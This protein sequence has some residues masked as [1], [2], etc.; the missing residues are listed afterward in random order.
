MNNKKMFIVR[1]DSGTIIQVLS[2]PVELPDY[3]HTIKTVNGSKIYTF[4][5]SYA[6]G[7]FPVKELK[8]KIKKALERRQ[9]IKDEAI[10]DISDSKID[11]HQLH[12]ALDYLE[13]AFFYREDGKNSPAYKKLQDQ[14]I[15]A[16]SLL[17]VI[18]IQNYI[19]NCF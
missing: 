15:N 1:D 11:D 5:F 4:V 8:E 9:W 17:E 18:R 3:F 7:I 16:S 13:I 19:L 6:V 14:I 12:V 2:L 10:E